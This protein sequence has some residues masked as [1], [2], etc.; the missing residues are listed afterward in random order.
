MPDC[1]PAKGA[2]ELTD[3]HVENVDQTTLK[4]SSFQENL[5]AVFDALGSVHDHVD[6]WVGSCTSDVSSHHLHIVHNSY[7]DQKTITAPSLIKNNN[8]TLKKYAFFLTHRL[9]GSNQYISLYFAIIFIHG[10]PA[11]NRELIHFFIP[12]IIYHHL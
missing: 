7:S 12:H 10:K 1:D 11:I 6:L 2:D 9:H 8:F 5:A 3:L 4:S